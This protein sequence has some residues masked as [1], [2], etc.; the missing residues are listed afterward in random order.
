M[1]RKDWVTTCVALALVLMSG[2]GAAAT[3]ITDL[4]PAQ[5]SR[6]AAMVVLDRFDEA[7]TGN[8]TIGTVKGV[9]CR[10][11][12]WE[13]APPSEPEAMQQLFIEAAKLDANAVANAV[14]EVKN[15]IDWRHNCH[16][17][18]VC[19]GEAVFAQDLPTPRSAAASANGGERPSP[20]ESNESEIK[21]VATGTGW[22]IAPGFIVTNEHVVADRQDITVFADKVRSGSSR[23]LI[24]DK[25]NDL[26]ILTLP[27]ELSV[28]TAIPVARTSSGLGATVFTIGFPMSSV[29]G[30]A[31]KVASGIVSAA[32]GL[33][34]DPRFY[35]TSIPLQPGNSGGP[36]LNERGEVIGITSSK[37]NTLAIA[38]ATGSVVEGV[39]YAVKIQYLAPLLDGLP[40]PGRDIAAIEPLVDAKLDAIVRVVGPSVVYIEAR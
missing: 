6:A 17:S 7:A 37:P 23:V 12:A 30:K 4:S 29:L 24:A 21:E 16:H 8:R 3:S 5:R 1:S 14:C 20:G 27:S 38:L 34:D 15:K 13:T 40:Q 25:A 28:A 19:V 9:S 32:S 35:Q 39:S 10:R 2:D 31:P 22:V 33:G 26:A 11:F 36:L 18:V